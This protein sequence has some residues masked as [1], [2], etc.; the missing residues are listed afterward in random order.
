MAVVSTLVLFGSGRVALSA[1]GA[2]ALPPFD[3]KPGELLLVAGGSDGPTLG[4]GRPALQSELSDPEGVAVSSNGDVY[5]A[6][7]NDNEVRVVL[8]DGRI[9]A[10]AGD[11]VPGYKGN[12]GPA[13]DAE[14]D[15]P[16]GV[17]VDSSGDVFIADSGNN[18][19]REVV[20]GVISTY[21]GNGT[22]GY[23][24]DGGSPTKAEL[25]DPTGVAVDQ[26]GDVAI[27]D[28]D[29]SVVREVV[30][31]LNN[32]GAKVPGATVHTG[33][34]IIGPYHLEMQTVAGDGGAGTTYGDGG[35]ATEATLDYP[36]GVAFD[37]DDNLYIADTGNSAIREVNADDTIETV[38]H[39]PYP[40]GVA[41]GSTGAI[42]M[43]D[44]ADNEIRVF[45]EGRY[46]P[47]A[48]NGIAG[49]KGYGGRAVKAELN[50]PEGI[51]L[52][53]YGDLY[54]ADTNND[55]VE[56]DVA[57]RAPVF[58]LDSPPDIVAAKGTYAYPFI[59]L[60]VPE[61][62]FSLGAGSPAWLS[63]N[64]TGAVK[65]TLPSGV[66]TFTYSVV[67]TNSSGSAT[68][69]PFTVTVP[70]TPLYVDASET[71]VFKTP[72]GLG[73]APSGDIWVADAGDNHVVELNA[74][75]HVLRNLATYDSGRKWSTPAG[76]ASNGTDLWVADYGNNRVEEIDQSTGALVFA[77]PVGQL[78][79]PRDVAVNGSGDAYV[80]DTGHDRIVEYSPAGVLVRTFGSSG[81]GNG[82]FSVPTDVAIGPDGFVYVT[83][84]GNKRVEEFTPD[85]TYLASYTV[86]NGN[87]FTRWAE[88]W[89]IYVDANHDI[90]VTD[91]LADTVTELSSTGAPALQWGIPGTAAKD[92]DRPTGI[93]VSAAGVITIGDELNHR[94]DQWGIPSAPSFT[95]DSPPLRAAEGGSYSYGFA[96]SGVPSPSYS[97]ASGAPNWLAISPTSGA[98]SGTVPNDITSFSYSVNAA[99]A[100]GSTTAGPF[101]VT[102]TP[103]YTPIA[104][105]TAFGT[106]QLSSSIP[107]GVATDSS[108]DVFVAN[109]DDDVIDEYSSSG[110]FVQSFGTEGYYDGDIEQPTGLAI[111]GD[112]LYILN[113][114]EIDVYD[115]ATTP[116]S[117]VRYFGS[118]G[119]GNGEFYPGAE[120]IAVDS[121]GDVWIADILNNRIEEFSPTGAY[122]SQIDGQPANGIAFDSSGDLVV[123]DS[124]SHSIDVM[125]TTG[126]IVQSI[127]NGTGDGAF[128]Y[129]WGVALDSSGNIY[130]TDADGCDVLEYS[131]TGVW[132]QTVGTCGSGAG[133][134]AGPEYLA[135]DSSGR[136]D[137]GDTGNERIVQF[138]PSGGPV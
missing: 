53:Q 119:A 96:A 70:A 64:A 33:G 37:D 97:L 91:N 80:V 107:D 14:L 12:G 131:G 78:S 106:A 8:P 49:A 88:P 34:H 66:K 40:T 9:Y 115:I 65:G 5:I 31:V 89:G 52:D 17:A 4:N 6:D 63:V 125:T 29:N 101:T 123:A 87:G 35:P 48:G 110:S 111:S 26:Y 133:Q 11:G 82:E 10:F 44:P 135:V 93:T 114:N 84:T 77:S 104:Y 138:A 22:A 120:G 71:G 38:V 27:A 90:W 24:G 69:G 75:A 95:T 39:S 3:A 98:L 105:S 128:N 94:V 60:G 121:S 92:F 43:T 13:V 72:V 117:L 58:Y 50:R 73:A 55:L 62:T 74:S 113:Y 86:S 99:N 19:I 108:G 59:A 61:P 67:A 51:G 57:P 46:F 116:P 54:I 83:D 23:S 136:V 2:S 32:D 103:P 7:A 102:V 68:A 127:S 20:G 85:G 81:T 100:S 124:V 137:V 79:D 118:Y 15:H 47:V 25:D 130:L 45:S 134:L 122:M 1:A 18:V 109:H 36:T 30:K 76:V 42:Y 56:E 112:D 21:A 126:S 41:V 28:T 132:L 129:P 16:T